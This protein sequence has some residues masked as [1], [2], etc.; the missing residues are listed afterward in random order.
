MSIHKDYGV[1]VCADGIVV[2]TVE[3]HREPL[4]FHEAKRLR[5]KYNSRTTNK[6]KAVVRP[7]SILS[8]LMLP[9][10]QFSVLMLRIFIGSNPRASA[11]DYADKLNRRST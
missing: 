2:P 6:N 10:T 4:T 11:S 7:V 9:S 8:G 3:V 1:Y 5:D